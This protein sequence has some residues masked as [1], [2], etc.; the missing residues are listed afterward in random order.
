MPTEPPATE[1][2]VTISVDGTPHSLPRPAGAR[3][4][5]GQLRPRGSRQSIRAPFLRGRRA[6]A[7]R[8]SR[9]CPAAP[10][11]PRSARRSAEPANGPSRRAASAATCA[12][13][14]TSAAPTS[15]TSPG[16]GRRPT[17]A[18]RR[19]GRPRCRRVGRARASRRCRTSSEIS[20]PTLHR[21]SVRIRQTI[22][23]STVG[24]RADG[25]SVYETDGWE[26]Q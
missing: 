12:D 8:R 21:K 23:T 7:S 22:A 2:A 4:G 18:S 13:G 16:S 11:T 14:T 3:S 17:R 5:S 1:S 25:D 9:T 24:S 10:P 20:A 6:R 19:A 15:A 26:L